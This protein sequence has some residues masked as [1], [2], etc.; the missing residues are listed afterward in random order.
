MKYQQEV[1]DW[2]LEEVSPM[3]EA[4]YQEVALSK[5]KVKYNPLWSFYRDAEKAGLFYIFTARTD[6]NKLV[7][8]NCYFINVHPHYKDR[9]CA[10]NDIF[11]ITPEYRG[12]MTGARLLDFS[13]QALINGKGVSYFFMHV[14]PEHD[15][16][17]LLTRR[18]YIL[19]EYIYSKLVN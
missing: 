10:Q 16:S 7:G 1:I 15:F 18:G 5:D 4:H 17:A 11:Y 2:V 9:L 14:K 19:H 3:L 8:Y 13:E 12:K 6:E